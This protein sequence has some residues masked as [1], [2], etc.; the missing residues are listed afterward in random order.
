HRAIEE[1]LLVLGGRAET[2]DRFDTG[3]VVPASIEQDELA[4]AW[5]LPRIA[6][7]I[8]LAGFTVIRFLQGNR[9]HMAVVERAFDRL[10]HAA[11]AGRIAAFEDD[12]HALAGGDDPVL[13]FEQ[14]QLQ[15][16]E[17]F[18]VLLALDRFHGSS[19]P[20]WKVESALAESRTQT[21]EV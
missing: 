4:G 21:G 14:L 9:A 13:Q 6:L 17:G 15:G 7:E 2:H 18:F 19:G 20:F 11:L 12:H 3:A 1:E 5:Q 8:P 16:F 10:D